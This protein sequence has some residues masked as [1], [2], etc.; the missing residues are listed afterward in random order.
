MKEEKQSK[1]KVKEFLNGKT[2]QEAANAAAEAEF[3]SV[4]EILKARDDARQRG[5]AAEFQRL[6]T[7]LRTSANSRRRGFSQSLAKSRFED[8]KAS[9]AKEAPQKKKGWDFSFF[10]KTRALNNSPLGL[11]TADQ[12]LMRAGLSTRKSEMDFARSMGTGTAQDLLSQAGLTPEAAMLG[13]ERERL[14]EE[15]CSA[16]YDEED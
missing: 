5:D 14:E 9:K 12:I 7:L 6:S 10:S 1:S 11:Q 15:L 3:A 8:L 13:A 2:V 16:S 4:S